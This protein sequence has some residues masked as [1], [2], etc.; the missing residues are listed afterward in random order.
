MGIAHESLVAPTGR[1]DLITGQETLMS[2]RSFTLA[3][4]AAVFAFTTVAA[5][6]ADVDVTCEKRSGRSKVSVDGND[7]ASGSY[8]AVISSGSATA[9]SGLERAVGDEAEFDFDSRPNDI[10]EGAT[11]ISANF[12]QDGRVRGWLVN[13]NGQRVTAVVRAICRV[14]R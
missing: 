13:A 11:A 6:A 2:L 10:A 4:A 12:I 14:R 5:Q 8:R 7:L 1:H 3:A 9:R